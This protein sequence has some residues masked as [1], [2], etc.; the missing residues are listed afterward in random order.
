MTQNCHR[1]RI[2][3]FENN[4]GRRRSTLILLNVIREATRPCRFIVI[5]RPEAEGA[6]C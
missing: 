4:S 6:L 5:R 1:A 3:A 2:A